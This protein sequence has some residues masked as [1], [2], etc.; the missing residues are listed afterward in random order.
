MVHETRPD[1]QRERVV[2][3]SQ[4]CEVRTDTRSDIELSLRCNQ[5]ATLLSIARADQR[6]SSSPSRLFC[7]R[8]WRMDSSAMHYMPPSTCMLERR[9]PSLTKGRSFCAARR[10]MSTTPRKEGF[11]KL[12]HAYR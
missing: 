7:S 6:H 9:T 5:H 12:F 3:V 8:S 10:H 4:R 11:E 1:F 2:K